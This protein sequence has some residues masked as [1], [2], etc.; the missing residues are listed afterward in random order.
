VH[1][2]PNLEEDASLD[3]ARRQGGVHCVVGRQSLQQQA[4]HLQHVRRLA[5]VTPPAVNLERRH[6]GAA[7][8]Q[9]LEG[10]GQLQLAAARRT[11]LVRRVEDLRPQQ[12]EPRQ[13]KVARRVCGLLL[14]G[15]QFALAVELRDAEPPRIVHRREEHA[16]SAI[17]AYRFLRERGHTPLE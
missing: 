16:R 11:N 2:R 8:Q 9:I 13:G 12:V 1:V 14:N 5:G 10:I 6:V 4:V 3:L 7:R 15:D 17:T